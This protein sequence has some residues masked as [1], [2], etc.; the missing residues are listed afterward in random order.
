M[1]RETIK[2]R[3]YVT[4]PIHREMI[5]L[6][7]AGMDTR[8]NEIEGV[9]SR[10]VIAKETAGVDAIV[11]ALGDQIDSEIMHEN[12][13]LKAIHILTSSS[14]PEDFLESGIDFDSAN[15]LGIC[16][17]NSPVMAEPIAD[18]TFALMLALSRRLI[19]ADKFV[20]EGSWQRAVGASHIATWSYALHI[21]SDIFDKTIG[22][23]GLGRIGRLVARRAKGFNMR[24]LYYDAVRQ[25]SVEGILG[26]E[27]TCLDDLL[28]ESDFVTLHTPPIKHIIGSR[29]LGL[30]KKSAFLINTARGR[31]VDLLALQEALKRSQIAGAGLDVYESDSIGSDSPL[32]KLNNVVLTHHMAPFTIETCKKLATGAI[33]NIRSALEGK[34]PPNLVNQPT[35]RRRAIA[36]DTPR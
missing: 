33:E 23:I 4:R 34:T 14:L 8:V 18:F 10:Q 29:E 36:T 19:E 16:I 12:K 17:T 30:M 28:R 22:I 27:F 13:N 1:A 25:P 31:N 26:V 3:V 11:G 6:L 32:S 15:K 24:V 2:P 7:Q 9:P 35:T 5:D 21:G 20:R